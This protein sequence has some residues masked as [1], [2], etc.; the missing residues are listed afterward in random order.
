MRSDLQ[1]Y[2]DGSGSYVKEGGTGSLYIQGTDVRIQNASGENILNGTSNGAVTLYYDNAAKIATTSSGINVTGTV[3]A[4]GL[5]VDGTASIDGAFGIPLTLDVDAG[6]NTNLQFNEGSA[7][8]WYLRSVTGS[9]DFN[10]Y[11]NGAS[12]LNISSGGDI[13]FYE[14]TGATPK[15]FWDASAESAGS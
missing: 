13:S 15:F 2:H 9:N 14:D 6:A 1:I 11:G 12:R 4:D 8:R 10:F 3:T 7:L 5:T